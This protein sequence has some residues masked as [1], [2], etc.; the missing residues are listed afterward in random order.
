MTI[1]LSVNHY[2]CIYSY[3]NEDDP[4]IYIG[5]LI[6]KEKKKKRPLEFSLSSL[7]FLFISLFF[8]T[9]YQ[10]ESSNRQSQNQYG[11]LSM[12]F[13]FFLF[14]SFLKKIL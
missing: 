14:L 11:I 4:Y 1:H 10:Y 2:G 8:I 13:S 12:Y 6:I 7:S 9:H 5:S 3:I